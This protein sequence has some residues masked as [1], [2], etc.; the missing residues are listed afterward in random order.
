MKKQLKL[1]PL[2]TILDSSLISLDK[3]A[4]TAENI[5][6]G[7]ATLIQLRAKGIG[8]GEFIKIAKEIKKTTDRAGAILIINDRVDV[9]LAVD[10]SGVHLGQNDMPIKEARKILGESKII[11]IS[12]NTLEQVKEEVQ[13]KLADYIAFGPIYETTTKKDAHTVQGLDKLKDIKKHTTLP[14]VA[15][16]GIGENNICDVIR[17]GADSCAIISDILN[18]DNIEEKTK[19]LIANSHK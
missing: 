7:G 2:Y 13:N 18:A 11:G 4:E 9:C 1:P 12:T 17:S 6:K 10:A 19:A 14:L 8:A 5:I 15:I 16:G 3:M